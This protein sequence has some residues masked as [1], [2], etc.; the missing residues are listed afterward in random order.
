MRARTIA[1]LTTLS[2]ALI[3][4]AAAAEEKAPAVK[5]AA[6]RVVTLETI[7]IPGRIQRP[8][9]VVDVNRLVPRAP[10]PE[11]RKSLVDRIGNAIEKDPF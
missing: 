11:L 9:A 10:L 5:Q 4:S 8:H 7:T 1:G 2:L 6:G 3:A